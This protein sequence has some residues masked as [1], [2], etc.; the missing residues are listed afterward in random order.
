[1]EWRHAGR[2]GLKKNGQKQNL[3]KCQAERLK[4]VQFQ[5]FSGQFLSL[6]RPVKNLGLRENERISG[7]LKF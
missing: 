2:R 4:I 3:K 7:Q 5:V 6:F 1:M